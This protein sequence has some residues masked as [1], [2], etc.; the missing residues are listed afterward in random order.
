M[1]RLRLPDNAKVDSTPPQPY[2]GFRIVHRVP[3]AQRKPPNLYDST[4]YTS[5]PGAIKLSATRPA[6]ARHDIPGVPGA[7]LILDVFTPEECLQI[8]QAASAIGFEKDEAA[9]GSA[10]V[11]SSVSPYSGV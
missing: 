3:A 10:R 7:F 8:V 5:Q 1:S 9:E 4:V 6:P 2:P 11:K